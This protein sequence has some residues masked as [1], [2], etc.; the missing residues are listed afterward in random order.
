MTFS[1]FGANQIPK[2]FLNFHHP[3]Q[4]APASRREGATLLTQPASYHMHRQGVS[5]NDSRQLRQLLK[6]LRG[7]HLS[8]SD[9]KVCKYDG[10]EHQH[11][12][13]PAEVEGKT[14]AKHE[15][16]QAQERFSLFPPADQQT[17]PKGHKYP[18]STGPKIWPKFKT[19][20]PI[21]PEE[22]VVFT[23]SSPSSLSALSKPRHFA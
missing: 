10:P 16:H 5:G 4:H 18:G 23:P 3:G 21:I 20:P 2:I 17:R 11:A 14:G 19:P 6:P 12:N 7:P 9:K 22:T 1:A 13:V 15:Q 8:E